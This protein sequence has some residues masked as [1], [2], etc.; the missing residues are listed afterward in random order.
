MRHAS[1]GHKA[2]V[3]EDAEA[4]TAA[5]VPRPIGGV[6][7]DQQLLQR[8]AK[9]D[10][11]AFSEFYDRYAARAFGLIVRIVHDRAAAEDVLQEVFLQVWNRA[12]TYDD[13]LSSPLAWVLLLAR[14]RSIDALRHLGAD[15]RLAARNQS[16]HGS[17]QDE[18]APKNGLREG[19]IQLDRLPP[20]QAEAIRLAYHGGMTCVQ[21]ADLL[22][23]PLGTVKTRVRLGI[24][25]LREIVESR[26][27]ECGSV[28]CRNEV[29]A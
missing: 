21:I 6:A 12:S 7:T 25:R 20:D 28:D 15:A 19:D 24:R 3:A 4:R 1:N 10:R 23:L 11:S 18:S 17:L 5:K 29:L 16:L 8:I 13:S 26:N 9:Q 27:T 14:G 22:G 2:A